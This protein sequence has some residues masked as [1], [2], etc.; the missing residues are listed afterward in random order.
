MTFEEHCIEKNIN[1]SRF[2]ST[3]LKFCSKVYNTFHFGL[4]PFLTSSAPEFTLKLRINDA[5]REVHRIQ[6]H[7]IGDDPFETFYKF[8]AHYDWLKLEHLLIQLATKFAWVYEEKLKE[9]DKMKISSRRKDQLKKVVKNP[10]SQMHT[11]NK[12][13]AQQLHWLSELETDSEIID[14]AC[15]RV[16]GNLATLKNKRKTVSS[17]HRHTQ[18]KQ[19][20]YHLITINWIKVIE[21]YTNYDPKMEGSIRLRKS[22]K[23]RVISFIKAAAKSFSNKLRILMR[24]QRVSYLVDLVPFNIDDF[25]NDKYVLYRLLSRKDMNIP[26][27]LLN[28]K[29]IIPVFSK[30]G[31]ELSLRCKTESA[32]NYLEQ[33]A[34][35]LIRY[36]ESIKIKLSIVAS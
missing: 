18:G 12:Y 17:K 20:S 8:D 16:T 3:F 14:R 36:F 6:F 28:T 13:L 9:I 33:S 2:S 32:Y 1:K 10:M 22:I 26:K 29:N 24:L 35:Y 31:H 15:Q 7:N 30:K 4:A 34:N 5:I 21:L 25:Q 11:S 27:K 23:Y 19:G